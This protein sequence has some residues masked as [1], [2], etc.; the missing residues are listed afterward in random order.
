M[1]M[2]ADWT[3]SKT[4]SRSFLGIGEIP[5]YFGNLTWLSVPLCAI[6]SSFCSGIVSPKLRKLVLTRG[7]TCFH[8][9]HAWLLDMHRLKREELLAL[10]EIDVYF[11]KESWVI[12]FSPYEQM[13]RAVGIGYTEHWS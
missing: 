2:P 5:M 11:N 1:E 7:D 4:D 12:G 10:T 8:W 13:M 3:L 6:R 9:L